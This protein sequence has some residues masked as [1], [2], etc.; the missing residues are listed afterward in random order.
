MPGWSYKT[1]GDGYGMQRNE[2]EVLLAAARADLR[3]PDIHGYQKV[4]CVY[5]RRP[6][7]AEAKAL[8]KRGHE[9]AQM[10]NR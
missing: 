10:R 8:R 9:G 3:N 1:I 6:T 5:G 7:S 4:Y 2:I